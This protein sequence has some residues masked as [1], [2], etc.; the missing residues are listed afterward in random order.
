MSFVIFYNIKDEVS[1]KNALFMEIKRKKKRPETSNY[2]EINK[3]KQEKFFKFREVLPFGGVIHKNGGKGLEY[4]YAFD[5]NRSEPL[6]H[7][8]SNPYSK[9]STQDKVISFYLIN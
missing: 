1:D 7:L 5:K 3:K 6:S 2:E 8:M 4:K 9:W